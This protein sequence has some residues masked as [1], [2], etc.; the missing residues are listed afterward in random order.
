MGFGVLRKTG[1]NTIEV[2]AGVKKAIAE[3][4]EIY[5]G[6]GIRLK[7]VYDETDY[8]NQSRALVINNI[9]VGGAL[10]IGVLLLFLGSLSSVMVI[11]VAIPVPWL[12]TSS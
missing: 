3:I 12:S 2:M 11:G 6:R 5:A 8:I 9:F 10:A 1:A 7:Q 4:N